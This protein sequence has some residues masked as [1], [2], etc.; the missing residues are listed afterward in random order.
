MLPAAE[1]EAGEVALATAAAVAAVA[2][3]V[4]DASMAV[5]VVD[6]PGHPAANAPM[7]EPIER[8]TATVATAAER[9]HATRPN[10]L[11]VWGG[12][13]FFDTTHC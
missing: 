2:A 4:L 12:S 10:N 5:V 9:M 7:K 8:M 13:C 11:W 1:S 6:G 3:V